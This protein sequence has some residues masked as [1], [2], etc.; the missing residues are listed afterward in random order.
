[1]LTLRGSLRAY[2]VWLGVVAFTLYHNVIYA[3]S[4]PF[5]PLFPIWITVLSLSLFALIGGVHVIDTEGMAN[6][7]VKRR[8][9]TRSA[10][11]LLAVGGL[12][13]CSGSRRMS[14][15]W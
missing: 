3:F 14:L 8:L 4:V 11:V 6:S 12:S 13:P 15:L 10:W 1:M 2:L 5:G 9:V 7:Y